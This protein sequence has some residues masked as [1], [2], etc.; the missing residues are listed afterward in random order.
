MDRSALFCN[1]IDLLEN[2]ENPTLFCKLS[3]MS[4]LFLSMSASVDKIH[5]MFL[6]YTCTIL[7]ICRYSPII[8]CNASYFMVGLSYI[9]NVL[10]GAISI[11]FKILWQNKQN[12]IH[13]HWMCCTGCHTSYNWSNNNLRPRWLY[14]DQVSSYCMPW[15][16]HRCKF[17]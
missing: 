17:L 11:S 7:F 2:L 12:K 4:H 13:T 14:H 3:G 8:H 10:E 16:K 15:K 9:N 5:S 6:G 1:S